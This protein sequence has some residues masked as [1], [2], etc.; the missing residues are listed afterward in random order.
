MGKFSFLLSVPRWVQGGKEGTKYRNNIRNVESTG[1]ELKK[2]ESALISQDEA[3]KKLEAQE[4]ARD[5]VIRDM[6][7]RGVDNN[8]INRY[9]AKLDD[10]QNAKNEIQKLKID[11]LNL[12]DIDKQIANLEK[13]IK[14]YNLPENQKRITHEMKKPENANLT[15]DEIKISGSK[16]TQKERLEKLD[17]LLARRNEIYNKYEMQ[18]SIEVQKNQYQLNQDYQNL[19]TNA[20]NP[21]DL[22]AVYKKSGLFGGKD[23]LA[24]TQNEVRDGKT[25]P[26][27]YIF[28]ITENIKSGDIILE[29][30][31]SRAIHFNPSKSKWYKLFLH[32]EDYAAEK[33]VVKKEILDVINPTKQDPKYP[34]DPKRTVPNMIRNPQW[35]KMNENLN[36]LRD[37]LVGAINIT[38]I[39]E[40]RKVNDAN[41]GLNSVARKECRDA[42]NNVIKEE[43]KLQKDN[44]KK[45]RAEANQIKEQINGHST[46]KRDRFFEKVNKVSNK[47]LGKDAFSSKN[48]L[49]LYAKAHKDIEKQKKLVDERVEKSGKHLQKAA[50][51]IGVDID[52]KSARESLEAINDKVVSINKEIKQ[53]ESDH[54]WRYRIGQVAKV[55]AGVGAIAG[56]A[57]GGLGGAVAVGV[58]GVGAVVGRTAV[59]GNL[60]NTA[61]DVGSGAVDILKQGAGAVMKVGAIVE[62]GVNKIRGKDVDFKKDVVHGNGDGF[63]SKK[64]GQL[65]NPE[66]HRQ[67]KVSDLTSKLVNSAD[68]SSSVSLPSQPRNVLQNAKHAIFHPKEHKHEKQE[69]KDRHVQNAIEQLGKNFTG[70]GGIIN[71]EQS[72]K[73]PSHSGHTPDPS[74]RGSSGRSGSI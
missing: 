48:D 66:H 53:H 23:K 28:N 56:V 34:N 7:N 22:K 4:T 21:V 51:K 64:S 50:D 11:Q 13:A 45:S 33:I 69:I 60:G 1:R 62:Y 59:D 18:L 9:N 58:V 42:L 38:P 27:K 68:P 8:V 29:Q 54:P 32:K 57:A 41:P 16:S 12:I 24:V 70:V 17:R 37:G 73:T 61:K 47:V 35:D 43:T 19:K 10:T 39:N 44:V 71:Q 63:F 65:M 26:A 55:A 72:G 49:D 5:A 40:Q 14:L 15:P 46:T 6:M 30:E 3:Q 74:R 36:N 2:F 25:Y 20:N 67:N 31:S 52:K